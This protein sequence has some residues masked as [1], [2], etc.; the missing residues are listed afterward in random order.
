MASKVALVEAKPSRNQYQ[1]LFDGL[2]FDHYHLTSDAS[3]KKVL[4]KDVDIDI[5]TDNYDWVI[6]V[7]SEPLKYFTKITS[8]TEYSG[9]VVDDKFLPV[10]NPAMLAFKPE[11]KPTW[12]ESK[13]NIIGYVNG[14]KEVFVPSKE[15][16]IGI[17]EE[18]K[19]YEYLQGVLQAPYDYVAVDTETTGLYP[20]DGYILGMSISGE[21]DKGAYISTDCFSDRVEAICQEI[22][23][24]KTVIF[25][26]AKFDIAMLEYHFGFEFPD[27]EDTMLIH[28]MLTEIPG[29]HGLKQLALKYTKYGD[30]EKPMYEWM[31]QFRKENRILKA[32]FL[33]EWIPF[34]IMKTYA[35]MDAA[36][37]FLLYEYFMKYLKKNDRLFGVYR[38]ILL[39]AV[40]F[41]IDVQDVGVPFSMSRLSW[42][43]DEMTRKITE[44]V[45]K[46]HSFPEVQ[47]FIEVNGEFN[48]N[49]VN[50]LRRLLFDFLG[51]SP[52]GK[53][54]EKGENSTDAEVLETLG[55]I[56]PVP[57]LILDI[58]K[59]S[60]IKNTY[61]D[62]IIPQ[63][64]MDMRLRTNFN[65]HGT[66]S[67]RLSSS[68]KMNM[69]QIPRDDPI[70]KGCIQAREGYKIVS[71]DLT[72]A[73]MYYAAVLSGDENLQEVF[74][75]GGNFHSTI[76]HK[77]FRLPCEIDE[78][79]ELYPNE[80]Q[81]AKAISFG[82]LYGAGPHKISEQ[83]RKDGGSLSVHGAV[84]VIDD[85]FRAFP[86][87]KKWIDKNQKD[88]K[89]N[90]F[91]YSFFG[92]KRRLPNVNSDNKG[93]V[94][95]EVRS[96]L[97]FL[98]QSVASD[99]NLIGAIEAHKE[100]KARN[101]GAKIFALVH[102][103]ILAEVPEEE[104]DE[105]SE[106]VIR[107]IQKDRG[108]SI[109]GAPIGC[110]LEIGNDYSFGKFD[111]TYGSEY[112]AQAA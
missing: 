85:Y 79:A 77:V 18:E 40:R 55:Q 69:Q 31:D 3:L 59:K 13:D 58:R 111:K 16:F 27:F 37:T 98:V 76:A 105:Y 49:S 4:K 21:P 32:D 10:I 78:V 102:D 19:A 68:G 71:I 50:Q 52:T 97:N 80:R 8:V 28:Y 103:S 57:K 34:D 45:E 83:V 14:H 23:N 88:I 5:D 75:M 63:L 86:K 2:E 53:K 24:T 81:A 107:N 56:H 91:A 20:R 110:D 44:D 66:T 62:K 42:A 93:L 7:G 65:L 17:D 87:L 95:H 100:L 82:I 89:K 54:T 38:N 26:N 84:E 72:T 36:V 51:L 90:G 104:V 112:N 25:H 35:S 12:E 15:H 11:A 33:W 70:V 109:P 39:P 48:P 22:F 108:I 29:T 61:L 60:K 1:R 73:E 96:G 92:R 43:Q 47:R 99:V 6:L 9:R 30:Y 94:G 41:L 46:L 64:N 67:G 101:S 106:I 74:K